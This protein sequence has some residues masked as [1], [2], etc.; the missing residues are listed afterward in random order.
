MNIMPRI[1]GK[2]GEIQENPEEPETVGKW[3]WKIELYSVDR[4]ARPTV[5]RTLNGWELAGRFIYDTEELAKR[6]L[7]EH[8]EKIGQMFQRAVGGDGTEGFWN[9]KTGEYVKTLAGNAGRSGN[10]S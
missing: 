1:R 10:V 9:L 3:T 2:V 5:H 4:K 7:E 6:G 8:G